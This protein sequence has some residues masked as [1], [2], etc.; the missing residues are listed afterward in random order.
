MWLKSN[1]SY[2]HRTRTFDVPCMQH[3][4]NAR[5]ARNAINARNA[6]NARNPRNPLNARN[7]RKFQKLAC[8]GPFKG[9][10][11]LPLLH[12]PQDSLQEAQSLQ[13]SALKNDFQSCLIFWREGIH[14]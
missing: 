10:K 12:H 3:A 7:A 14:K 1:E 6:R 4:R 5:N 2:A 13:L 9:K 8:L 11:Y